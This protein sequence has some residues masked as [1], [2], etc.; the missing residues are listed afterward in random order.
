MCV[1]VLQ[2][3]CPLAISKCTKWKLGHAF[4]VFYV[5]LTWHFKKRKKSRF[6]IL[7]KTQKNVFSNYER[8]R[9][10]WRQAWIRFFRNVEPNECSSQRMSRDKPRSNLL[11]PVTTTRDWRSNKH[12]L[13]L[14][15]HLRRNRQ[16]SVPRNDMNACTSVAADSEFCEHRQHWSCL[17]PVE[18]VMYR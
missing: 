13:I 5:F 14:V 3:K 6:W 11:L 15:L 12:A 4:Y 2:W 9:T 7:K 1:I 16:D 8:S 10:S 17:K 18:R